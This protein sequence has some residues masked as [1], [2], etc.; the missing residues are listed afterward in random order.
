MADQRKVE[1]NTVDD[2]D[3]LLGPLGG[4]GK[5]QIINISCLCLVIF[6]CDFSELG[7]VF[8]AGEVKHR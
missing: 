3:S 6:L 4:F 5:F 2:L 1:E 7:Y 8:T